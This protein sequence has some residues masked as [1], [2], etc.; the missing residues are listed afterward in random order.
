MVYMRGMICTRVLVN[1]HIRSG[2]S[3]RVLPRGTWL[4]ALCACMGSRLS[5]LVARGEESCVVE[6][7]MGIVRGL[8][9][10]NGGI[11]VMYAPG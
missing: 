5:V 1:L 9:A 8:R 2:K 4:V 10:W 3:E 6:P 11:L 7:F